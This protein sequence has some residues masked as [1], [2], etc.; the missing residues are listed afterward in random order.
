[1]MKHKLIFFSLLLL[2]SLVVQAIP[3]TSLKTEF[4]ENSLGI[5]TA[6][7]R[8]SWIVQD[9]MPGA[10]Q[11]AYQ[12]Q[13][14]VSPEFKEPLLWDSGRVASEQSHLVEYAG[15]PLVSRQQVWWRVKSWGKDG[16]DTGWSQPGRFEVGLL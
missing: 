5:D 16:K 10:K 9:T 3:P 13:A 14:A 6:K 2:A 4:L 1:M 12:L 15:K 7:P 11:T 8:F